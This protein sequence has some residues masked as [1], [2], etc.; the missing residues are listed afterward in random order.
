MECGSD[1]ACGSLSVGFSGD[2][3]QGLI[4]GSAVIQRSADGRNLYAAQS[5]RR[6]GN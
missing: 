4:S 1:C 3:V 2:A 5:D 6:F